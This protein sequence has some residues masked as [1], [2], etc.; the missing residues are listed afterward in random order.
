MVATLTV[1]T[2]RDEMPHG[3]CC[4]DTGAFTLS[5]TQGTALGSLDY[6]GLSEKVN[7]NLADFSHVDIGAGVMRHRAEL[8]YEIAITDDSVHEDSEDFRVRMQPAPGVAGVTLDPAT[9]DQTVTITD[10]DLPVVTINAA[11]TEAAEGD[12]LSLTVTRDGS[13]HADL[14]VTVDVSEDGDLVSTANAGEQTVTILATD[15]SATFTVQ[16]DADDATWD[17]HS[18]VTVTVADNAVHHRGTP[19]E[20]ETEVKDDDFPA[21]TAVL[22]FDGGQSTVDEGGRLPVW[23][24]VTVDAPNQ[25]PHQ[26]QI[27]RQLRVAT[28]EASPLSAVE[29]TDYTAV[30]ALKTIDPGEFSQESDGR[31]QWR[32]RSY[33]NVTD[34]TDTEGAETF[35]VKMEAVTSDIGLITYELTPP[36]VLDPSTATLTATIAASDAVTVSSDATL[37][38]LSF[39]RIAGFRFVAGTETYR[40]TP[41]VNLSSTTVRAATTDPGASYIVKLGGVEDA[42]RVIMLAEGENVITVVVTAEDGEN[43]KTYTVTVDNPAHIPGALPVITSLDGDEDVGGPF[44][45]EFTFLKATNRVEAMPVTGFV[46]SDITVSNG[47]VSNLVKVGDSSSRFYGAIWEATI[48]P[49]PTARTWWSAWRRMWWQNK[50]RRRR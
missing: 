27:E 16:T 37:R 50:T 29:G 5:T 1:T 47:A 30:D 7:F 26:P 15:A 12:L 9:A 6:S 36:I 2:D 17:E 45:V 23:L 31:W 28:E 39:S 22:S 20:A 32:N 44:T 25:Q 41:L 38:G 42:D 18:T 14:I 33:I 40:V 46:L 3:P 43:T 49:T 11:A 8:T 34:D 4:P 10:D 24:T 21:A 48:T 19:F 35:L 13:T